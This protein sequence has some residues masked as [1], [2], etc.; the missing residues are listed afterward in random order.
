MFVHFKKTDSTGEDGSF[1][2]KVAATEALDEVAARVRG[3]GPDVLLVTGDHSTPS[4]DGDAQLA[5]RAGA[6][7]CG[8][9]ERWTTSTSFGESACLRG[10]LGIDPGDG[11]DAAHAGAR[12]P[13]EEVRSVGFWRGA[14]GPSSRRIAAARGGEGVA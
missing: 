3:I 8:D 13:S 12:G 2:A 14:V 10:S 4:S 9:G 11:P 5:P 6:R 1:D 7:A